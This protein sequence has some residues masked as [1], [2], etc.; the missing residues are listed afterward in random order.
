M[1]YKIFLVLTCMLIFACNKKGE[2]DELNVYLENKH[3]MQAINMYVTTTRYDS[4]VILPTNHLFNFDEKKH[5]FLLGPLYKDFL[6]ELKDSIIIE[7]CE[8]SHKKIYVI[9]TIKNK[10]RNQKEALNI[11]YCNSDSF[12]IADYNGKEI[13]TY[14]NLI[15][16]LKRAILIYYNE[17]HFLTIESH[18]DTIVLPKVKCEYI[19]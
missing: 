2:K 19:D 18:P 6:A 7:F 14:S 10:K 15:N 13:Y 4:Y 16:F 5:G 11:N 8:V 9:P 17:K 1:K 12:L 3:F